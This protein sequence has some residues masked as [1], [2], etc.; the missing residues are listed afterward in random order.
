MLGYY[1]KNYFGDRNV[2]Q[3]FGYNSFNQ[4][5]FRSCFPGINIFN[6]GNIGNI[7]IGQ[8]QN[9]C[10]NKKQNCGGFGDILNLLLS[11]L[12]PKAKPI[13][14]DKTEIE[15]KPKSS[16][17]LPSEPAKPSEPV[18]GYTKTHQLSVEKMTQAQT[19]KFFNLYDVNKDG[20]FD[21]DEAAALNVIKAGGKAEIFG[22]NINNMW[23][24]L[25]PSK[26]PSE[27]LKALEDIKSGKNETARQSALNWYNSGKILAPGLPGSYV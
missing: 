14:V 9:N 16:E 18:H 21:I 22:S 27:F 13:K 3:N 20:V 10:R 25:E 1:N 8:L 7:N 15:V 19:D 5:N 12:K 23:P 26:T 11:L 17:P 6:Y 2:Y 24:T 4:R